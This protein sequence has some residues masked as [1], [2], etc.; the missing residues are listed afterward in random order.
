MNASARAKVNE[1]VQKHQVQGKFAYEFEG[2]VGPRH[3]QEWTARALYDG[4]EFGKG[5]GS[6]KEAA[7]EAAAQV[8]LGPL[9]RQLNLRS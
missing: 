4:L 6:S 7:K 8:A 5:K 9:A 2:P 3:S 1:L